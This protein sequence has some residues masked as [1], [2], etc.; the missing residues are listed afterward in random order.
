MTTNDVITNALDGGKLIEENDLEQRVERIP[1]KIL[2]IKQHIMS[3]KI[4][5]K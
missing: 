5:H 1:T 4:F 2:D 3:K